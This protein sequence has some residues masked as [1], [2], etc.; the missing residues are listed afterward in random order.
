MRCPLRHAVRASII[1]P[2]RFFF[3]FEIV[4]YGLDESKVKKGQLIKLASRRPLLLRV[5]LPTKINAS[6]EIRKIKAEGT[7]F[8]DDVREGSY[9]NGDLLRTKCD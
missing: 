3:Y 9:G 6:N 1:F 8:S 4:K 5:Q 2:R 7:F